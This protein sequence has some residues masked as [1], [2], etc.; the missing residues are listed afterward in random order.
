MARKLNSEEENVFV[1]AWESAERSPAG[2]G[3]EWFL[4]KL[5]NQ[6]EA[7]LSLSPELSA[8]FGVE[9]PSRFDS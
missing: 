3:D 8:W 6:R 4:R 7:A 2:A 1:K 5:N 9:V